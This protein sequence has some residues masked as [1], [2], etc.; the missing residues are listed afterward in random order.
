MGVPLLRM[1]YT[2]KVRIT[3]GLVLSDAERRELQAQRSPHVP[4]GDPEF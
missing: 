3:H 2:M 1:D 4:H